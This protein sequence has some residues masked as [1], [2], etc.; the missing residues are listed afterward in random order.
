MLSGIKELLGLSGY[1]VRMIR[2]LSS[3]RVPG[4]INRDIRVIRVI[5]VIRVINVIC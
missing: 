2:A 1:D 3:S 4:V 5:T